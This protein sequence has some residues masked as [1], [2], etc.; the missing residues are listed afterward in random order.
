MSKK[1][2]EVPLEGE[3][4]LLKNLK[5]VRRFTWSVVADKGNVKVIYI[6]TLYFKTFMAFL[7]GYLIAFAIINPIPFGEDARLFY[8]QQPKPIA[9]LIEPIFHI[10]HWFLFLLSFIYKPLGQ[11]FVLNQ[12]SLLEANQAGYYLL[13][14]YLS[15]SIAYIAA[16]EAYKKVV[17][18]PIIPNKEEIKRGMGILFFEKAAE[19]YNDLFAKTAKPNDV[20]FTLGGMKITWKKLSTHMMIIG[21]SGTG[22]T[23]AIIKF[24]A[25][26]IKW[27]IKTSEGIIIKNPVRLVILDP[28]N[29]FTPKFYDES[30]PAHVL[31]DLTDERS[32][33]IDYRRD[34]STPALIKRLA[35]SVI[36]AGKDPTWT[37]T[38]QNFLMAL[39]LF[40]QDNFGSYTE[41]EIEDLYMNASWKELEWIVN[42]YYPLAKDFL[43]PKR[44]DGSYDEAA[45]PNASYRSTAHNYIGEFIELGHYVKKEKKFFSVREFMLNPK[46][47]HKIVFIR[48][49]TEGGNSAQTL[50]RSVL[51]SMSGYI[52]SNEMPLS[53]TP[54]HVFLFEEI[55]GAGKLVDENGMPILDRLLERSR[56]KG[57]C[58]ITIMQDLLQIRDVYDGNEKI[59]EKWLAN[60]STHIYA[61]FNRGEGVDK[62]SEKMGKVTVG[63]LNMNTTYDKDMKKER[64]GDKSIQNEEKS[65]ITS[66]E[67]VELL[68]ARDGHINVLV[69]GVNISNI[70]IVKQPFVTFPDKPLNNNHP[71]RILKNYEI[72]KTSDVLSLVKELMDKE[73][74]DKSSDMLKKLQDGEINIENMAVQELEEA[75][76]MLEKQQ[77]KN[78]D[79][80]K[81]IKIDDEEELV[82]ELTEEE[83][84]RREDYAKDAVKQK[85]SKRADD[86]IEEYL[87]FKE[88][89][90][91]DFR[92]NFIVKVNNILL[93]TSS[94]ASHFKLDITFAL[95]NG[96]RLNSSTAFKIINLLDENDVEVA[97]LVNSLT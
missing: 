53:K 22:K 60:S 27:V 96:R 35:T 55:A 66:S 63:K 34:L 50:A 86:F 13:K 8:S 19:Y 56:A 21:A 62:L 88:S 40:M 68:G 14:T 73:K 43:P 44:A 32:H 23:Q 41:R 72:P 1:E 24:V 92:R 10:W 94:I 12:L 2:I 65:A 93:E 71:A 42:R 28:K 67:L 57:G 38:P 31:I 59:I 49:N 95:K 26:L 84:A 54:K 11:T 47:P 77:K 70:L 18:N 51:A 16:A 25:K 61:G 39:F 46:C 37:N 80:A 97:Y 20:A 58:V 5:I 6:D 78:L 9:Y 79:N 74:S 7:I 91:D 45:N 3:E 15:F 87:K 85:V 69:D 52:D 64:Y 29:E 48:I 75:K 4:R 30:N 33:S 90:S 83:V 82:V 76:T 36:P 17:S 81:K 89:T